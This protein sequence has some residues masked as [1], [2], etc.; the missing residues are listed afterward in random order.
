[1]FANLV[2][3]GGRSRDAAEKPFWISYA[4][5]MTALMVLFLVAMSVALLAVTK[6]I[7]EEDRRKRSHEEAI[8]RLL[9]QLEAVTARFPGVKLD[10]DRKVIDFQERVLF[11]KNEYHLREE[12]AQLLRAFVPN[13][14][15][16]ASTDLG[17]EV[18]KRVV[19][20]GFADQSG[21][22]LYNLNLSLQ[23]SQGVLCGLFA[24]S[25]QTETAL[26]NAQLSQIRELFVVGGY[27]FN[28]ARAT[29]AESRR[30]EL[31]LELYTVDENHLKTVDVA[32]EN[33][34]DCQ[35]R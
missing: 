11:E 21:T 24:H 6:R 29:A 25:I 1:V 34:G 22:Y 8:V 18:L 31:R 5:L 35:L 19:I 2:K 23:R 4:D 9:D 15:T 13:V 27:S 32:A 3:S 7:S 14:L 33:F 28:N 20:E 30:V 10:R 26:T 16:I 17:K 12:Q